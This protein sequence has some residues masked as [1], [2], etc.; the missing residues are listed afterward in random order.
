MAHGFWEIWEFWDMRSFLVSALLV[1]LGLTGGRAGGDDAFYPCQ[2]EART[3]ADFLVG[4]WQVHDAKT[5]QLI[6]IDVI[7]KKLEGCALKQNWT[8]IEDVFRTAKVP[9]RMRGTGFF[10][11]NDEN[12]T[13]LWVDNMASAVAL[14]GGIEEGALVMKSD[15]ARSGY[16]SRWIWRPV[17]GGKLRNTG[18]FSE[19]GG[20]TWK[21]SF[22]LIYKSN[23]PI[24]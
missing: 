24:K 10:S 16:L 14:R 11:F 12:W 9:Y 2:T 23:R 4:D 3:A 18:F 13:Y 22:D 6:A 21:Q 7:E 5:D 19:D 20:K 17:E 8:T 1:A 15:F